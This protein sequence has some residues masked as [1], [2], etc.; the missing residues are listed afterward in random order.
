MILRNLF[1]KVLAIN[2]F[3]VISLFFSPVKASENLLFSGGIERDHCM[4]WVNAYRGR[5]DATNIHLLKVSN[6]NTRKWCKVSSNLTYFLS[7]SII[8]FEH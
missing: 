5:K 7:V 6:R 1:L 2:P 3:H 8:E 4:N